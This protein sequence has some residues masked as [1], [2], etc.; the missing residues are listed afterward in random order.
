MNR[1]IKVHKFSLQFGTFQGFKTQVI[2]T[3]KIDLNLNLCS[4]PFG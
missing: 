2:K 1:A 3:G 4:P